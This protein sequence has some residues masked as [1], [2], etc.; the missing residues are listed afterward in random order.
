M[1]GLNTASF[2]GMTM[3]GFRLRFA[4]ALIVINSI[5]FACATLRA[6]DADVSHAPDFRAQERIAPLFF[7]PKPGAP[8]MAVA[9]TTWVR[10]LPDGSS[11]THEN[12]RVVARD[13][14]G[15]IFQ[16]R[17]TFTPVPNVKNQQ[18]E[19]YSLV[20]SDP[21]AHVIYGCSVYA[22]ICNLNYYYEAVNS[23]EMPPGVQ[24]DGMSYLTRENLGVDRFEGLDVQRTRET[25][26]YYKQ[27]VGN[28]RT[29]LR[30]IDYWYSPELG[31]NVKVVRHDPRDGDQILWLS[32]I[33]QSVAD[34]SFFQVPAGFRVIDRR[35][36]TP[37]AVRPAP[38]QPVPAR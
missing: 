37:V 35:A 38:P 23:P 16:E 20:Y 4:C 2:R 25:F 10:T 12:Q 24:P 7:P 3:T 11:E 1:D 15:R 36:A 30:V 6:Q 29:I 34:S 32:D 17:R 31:I 19:A 21:V 9:K 14:D 5:L 18:S 33:S 13:M 27:T 28:T 22:K 26:T 8:F